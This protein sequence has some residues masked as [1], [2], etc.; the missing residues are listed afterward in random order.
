[1]AHLVYSLGSGIPQ[2]N[3]DFLEKRKRRSV[4]RIFLKVLLATICLTTAYSYARSAESSRWEADHQT[5]CQV[6]NENPQPN[7]TITWS[8]S[9][10][11]GYAEGLGVLD[12]FEDG[13]ATSH[14]QGNFK[15]GRPSGNAAITFKNGEIFNGILDEKGLAIGIGTYEWPNGDKF[16]GDFVKELGLPDIKGRFI[17]S[18]QEKFAAE[19]LRRLGNQYFS[20]QQYAQAEEIYNLA[21][22][23]AEK[24]KELNALEYV[25]INGTLAINYERQ[26]KFYEA[27]QFHLMALQT[28]ERAFGLKDPMVW[29]ALDFIGKFYF[30]QGRNKEAEIIYKRLAAINQET[31]NPDPQKV[32]ATIYS[33]ARVYTAEKRYQDAE[34]AYKTTI[35]ILQNTDTAKS[36]LLTVMGNLAEL[37]IE[38]GEY[39]NAEIIYKTILDICESITPSDQAT[40][41]TSLGNLADA[42]SKQG[43][44]TEA[45]LLLQKGLEI[46]EHSLGPEHIDVAFYLNSLALLYYAEHRYQDAEPLFMRSL[47]IWQKER[48]DNSA[49]AATLLGNI[50]LLYDDQGRYPEAELFYKRALEIYE[51]EPGADYPNGLIPTL[52]ALVSPPR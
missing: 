48:G 26:N 21:L 30:S 49:E 29:T 31:L 9:C 52:G 39:A 46:R 16:E 33:L 25:L 11:N 3:V 37:Y 23:K 28:S 8:G 47:A 14:H 32:T 45:Q 41:A 4:M 7:E 2:S 42:I 43:R 50:G 5:G 13:I 27:E 24:Y 12:W 36:S 6:W 20:K 15:Q 35:E 10:L 44:I 17:F 18:N 22:T 19:T 1:M 40:I 34:T 38:T 51:T